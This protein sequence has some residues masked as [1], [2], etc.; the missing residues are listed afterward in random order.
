MYALIRAHRWLLAAAVLVPVGATLFMLSTHTP[1]YVS[2]GTYVVRPKSSSDE[3]VIRATRGLTDASK[4]E[5]TYAFI[6]ESDLVLD[7]ARSRIGADGAVGEAVRVEA[8]IVPGADMLTISAFSDDPA[9]AHEM[10]TAVGIEATDYLDTFDSLFALVPLDEPTVP[11]APGRFNQVVLVLTVAASLGLIA[12]LGGVL[13]FERVV[14]R[15][16]RL[17]GRGEGW[18]DLGI[19]D[20]EYTRLRLVEEVSRADA[21]GVPFR[22]AIIE[23]DGLL[24][25]PLRSGP[26][27]RTFRRRTVGAINSTVG[28]L[29]HVGQY[30]ESDSGR[31]AAVL[32][33]VS[34]EEMDRL[35]EFWRSA[36]HTSS[37]DNS[38]FADR[39]RIHD[40]RYEDG[41]FVGAPEAVRIAEQLAR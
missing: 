35:T 23:C 30:D 11:M 17:S 24:K 28:A 7:R 9:L 29:C 26:D 22:V 32:P 20:P 13:L 14:G 38:A 5:A 3:E 12:G 31:M 41:T 15:Y 1:E 16:R 27:P 10:A 36:I 33:D 18:G 40:C 37:R 19:D 2:M 25:S 6:T 39:L 4:I 21:G 34:S 8:S